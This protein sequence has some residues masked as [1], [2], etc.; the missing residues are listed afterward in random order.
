MARRSHGPRA[1]PPAPA[2]AYDVTLPP[3]RPAAQFCLYGA[4]L[5][6][7]L[8]A[9]REAGHLGE[10]V[11]EDGEIVVGEALALGGG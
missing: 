2:R 8:F 1:Q 11:E 7:E 5:F 6:L 3:R 9:G 4:R 10:D